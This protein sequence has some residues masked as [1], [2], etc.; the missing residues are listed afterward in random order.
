MFE[1]IVLLNSPSTGPTRPFLG[2]PTGDG[3][4]KIVH[5]GCRPAMCLRARSWLCS[6][7]DGMLFEAI[8]LLNRPY[9]GPARWFLWMMRGLA[10]NLSIWDGYRVLWFHG[11]RKLP[12]WCFLLWCCCHSHCCCLCLR[13]LLLRRPR[14][15]FHGSL[16]RTGHGCARSTPLPIH[17]GLGKGI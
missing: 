17:G 13:L 9:T 4:V 11:F 6:Y 8:A 7:S 15:L 12:M 14:C 2:G 16:F 1:A 3:D 10:E 5:P